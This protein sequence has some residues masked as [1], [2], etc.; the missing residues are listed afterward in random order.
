MSMDP[1]LPDKKAGPLWDQLMERMN[2]TYKDG[3]LPLPVCDFQPL[4]AQ[5]ILAHDAGA[6]EA[7]AIMCRAAIESAGWTLMTHRPAPGGGWMVGQAIDERGKVLPKPSLADIIAY[8]DRVGA[9][10]PSGRSALD[11]IKDDG[12]YA[13]H[14][15]AKLRARIDHARASDP[16]GFVNGPIWLNLSADQIYKNLE[17]TGDILMKIIFAAQAERKAAGL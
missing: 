1:I 3:N 15:S 8:L 11:R 12:D 17:E 16:R 9:L 5:A 10:S 6:R 13:A 14:Y 4:Y 7:S 2:R